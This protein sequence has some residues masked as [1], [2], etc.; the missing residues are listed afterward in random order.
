[1]YNPLAGGS[2]NTGRPYGVGP[3]TQPVYNPLAGGSANTGRPPIGPA[4]GPVD[5]SIIARQKMAAARP[6]PDLG[7]YGP[8]SGNAQRPGPWTP[9]AADDPRRYRGPLSMFGSS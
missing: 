4:P 3:P 6:V 9:L 7:Y 5:P 2:A 8:A 1:M